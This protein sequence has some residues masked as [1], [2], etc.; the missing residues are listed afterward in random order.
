MIAVPLNATTLKSTTP[1]AVCFALLLLITTGLAAALEPP[2]RT[3]PPAKHYP[4]SL[5]FA[6]QQDDDVVRVN[7]DLVVLNATVLGKDGEFVSGLRR[8]DFTIFED[9]KEQKLASFSAE[10]TAF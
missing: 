10:E 7:T 2:G 1:P 3:S 8:A 6:Q 9:G 4:P 5:S